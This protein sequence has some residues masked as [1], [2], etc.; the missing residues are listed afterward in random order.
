MAELFY[1]EDRD[2]DFLNACE[3][4]RQESEKHLSVIEMVSMAILKPAKS[5]Y[6]RPREY[7]DIIRRAKRELPK[8]EV[9]REMYSE[10]L[11]RY[12]ALRRKYPLLKNKEINK[13]LAEQSAPRFYISVSRGVQL[14]YELMKR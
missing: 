13:M 11:A 8:R 3:L 4:V 7:G 14:Y 6:L 1:R 10:I 12:Y 9:T 5:F 2:Q